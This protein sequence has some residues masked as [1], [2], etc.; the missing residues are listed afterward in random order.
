VSAY[1][2]PTEALSSAITFTGSL[3][4]RLQ[5][6]RPRLTVY[7]LRVTT[8]LIPIASRISWSRAIATV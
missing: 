8:V 7:A 4:L 2:G 6:E 1:G 3:G 5:G